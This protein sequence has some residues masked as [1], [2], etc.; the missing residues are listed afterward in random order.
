MHLLHNYLYSLMLN[1]YTEKDCIYASDV[2]Q[3]NPH[4]QELSTTVADLK[5][6][7][8]ERAAATHRVSFALPNQ[9]EFPPQ[10]QPQYQ[11]QQ[12]PL[13][14]QQQQPQQQFC[15]PQPA[16]M[17]DQNAA[18]PVECRQ[19]GSWPRPQTGQGGAGE[20]AAAQLP[21]LL[22]KLQRTQEK[23]ES[24]DASARKYKVR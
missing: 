10:Q 20:A 22:Q 8:N 12:Q 9:Q 11:Q 4:V 14:Y 3:E 5:A 7:T 21:Q 23:L 13:Q 2:H 1:K 19:S 17:W 6:Q 15:G 16:L 18:S 24:R